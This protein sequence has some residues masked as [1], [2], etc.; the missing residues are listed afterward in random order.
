[1]A[2]ELKKP[3]AHDYINQMISIKAVDGEVTF[4]VGISRETLE[5]FFGLD[6]N[7]LR[8]PFDVALGA[9]AFKRGGAVGQDCGRVAG[10]DAQNPSRGGS[11]T[12][13]DV[14]VVVEQELD[15]LCSGTGLQRPHEVG[16]A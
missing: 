15:A 12:E 1:M 2:F 13:N 8:V 16:A 11:L 7:R 6:G 3:Q 5:D 10:L 4:E 14:H 9:E